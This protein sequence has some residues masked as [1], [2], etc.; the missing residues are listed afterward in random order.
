M[1]TTR[2]GA[3]RG[4]EPISADLCKEDLERAQERARL[5]PDQDTTDPFS[6]PGTRAVS[7]P[8]RR[9]SGVD[10]RRPDGESAV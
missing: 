1:V 4:E 10:A 3:T 8:A 5:F 6:T 9:A 2:K 7:V